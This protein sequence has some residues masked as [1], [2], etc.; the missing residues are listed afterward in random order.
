CSF[1]TL[2]KSNLDTHYRRHTKEKP[3]SCPDEE[4]EFATCDPAS[5]LR[6]RKRHHGYTP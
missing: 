4:C 1:K 5:L 6:H 3:F 2:Q